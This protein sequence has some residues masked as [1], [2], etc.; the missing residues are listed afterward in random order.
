MRS[1][2]LD[3]DR[4]ELTTSLSKMLASG[5]GITVG[6]RA[7]SMSTTI[8][9]KLKRVFH[10]PPSPSVDVPTQQLDATRAHFRDYLQNPDTRLQ[11][12]S[13]TPIPNADPFSRIGLRNWPARTES[14]PPDQPS[15]P[16]ST[17]N[18]HNYESLVDSNSR[19]TSWA[20]STHAESIAPHHAVEKKRLSVIQEHGGPHQPS[21][22]I[23][24][25]G[26]SRP[27]FSAFCEP[28]RDQSAFNDIVGSPESQRMC[29]ALQRRLQENHD[30]NLACYSDGDKFDET[31]MPIG[32]IPQPPA[33]RSSSMGTQILL[34]SWASENERRSREHVLSPIGSQESSLIVFEEPQPASDNG[35]L[36][37]GNAAFEAERAAFTQSISP[38]A[39]VGSLRDKGS[40]ERHTKRLLRDVRSTFFP[41]NTH[42]ERHSTSP[43]RRAMLKN[44]NQSA[45]DVSA[46]QGSPPVFLGVPDRVL[47]AQSP[48]AVE[49]GSIY[50]R[51]ADDDEPRQSPQS[52]SEHSTTAKSEVGTAKIF[53][54]QSS[55]K[56]KSAGHARGQSSSSAKSS[57][58]WKVWMATEVA[59][60]DHYPPTAEKKPG[61]VSGHMKEEAQVNSDD[62]VGVGKLES[63]SKI[64][65]RCMGTSTSRALHGS[66]TEPL[67]S[68]TLGRSPISDRR[69][70][71]HMNEVTP[72]RSGR[73]IHPIQRLSSGQDENAPP[74]HVLKSDGT[75]PTKPPYY[76]LSC[77][78]LSPAIGTRHKSTH[79][80]ATLSEQ[81]ETSSLNR[82]H[83]EPDSKRIRRL[84]RIKSSRSTIS[85]SIS[86]AHQQA[87]TAAMERG[88]RRTV[89]TEPEVV[90]KPDLK[91]SPNMIDYIL[92]RVRR[93]VSAAS[94]EAGDAAFL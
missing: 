92:G 73:T 59:T 43:Y 77:H 18:I 2:S 48:S 52:C 76:S 1:S 32:T 60:L 78:S 66:C 47:G 22:S 8:K 11:D 5:S 79:P 29:S 15:H 75:T 39:A 82:R 34:N 87:D 72:V 49:S 44:D 9:S 45:S 21:S 91:G 55:T 89:I 81:Q 3:S 17:H 63:E 12:H 37:S 58:D 10:G 54:D 13:V 38:N 40:S 36:R 85:H 50:S 69:Q 14:A 25:H 33:R 74:Q 88:P 16:I 84:R 68:S 28:P 67:S 93:N 6:Q 51:S 65:R 90:A 4:N 24:M 80:T 94:K 53:G 56:S 41:P 70:A 30:I 27:V 20:N 46:D 42:I 86:D 64:A 61:R 26:V 35:I 31:L 19:V 83:E 23:F 62:E 71:H 7:R 57:G